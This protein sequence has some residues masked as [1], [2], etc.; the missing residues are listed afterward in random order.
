MHIYC[1]KDEELV[2][3]DDLKNKVGVDEEK[4]FYTK[5]NLVDKYVVVKGSDTRDTNFLKVINIEN[6]KVKY[7]LEGR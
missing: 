5:C 2:S 7:Y 3:A 1:S 4:F 6:K